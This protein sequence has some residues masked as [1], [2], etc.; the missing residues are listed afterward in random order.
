MTIDVGD[1]TTHMLLD[2]LYTEA[3]HCGNFAVGKTIEAVGE[4]DLACPRLHALY[5][6]LDPPK[7][8]ARLE[9]QRR[10]WAANGVGTGVGTIEHS[11]PTLTAMMVGGDI[12][13]RTI[14]IGVWGFDRLRIGSGR[15]PQ[16]QLLAKI[17]R[18]IRRCRPAEKA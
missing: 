2:R 18:Q 10:I 6:R 5:R 8:I 16:E 15:Q 13:R 17:L 12:S 3:G 14:E 7:C 1:G 9:R 4:E 11:P